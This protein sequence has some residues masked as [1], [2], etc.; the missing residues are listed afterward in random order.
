MPIA[1]GLPMIA[2]FLKDICR[3]GIGWDDMRVIRP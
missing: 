2:I 3:E 1:P